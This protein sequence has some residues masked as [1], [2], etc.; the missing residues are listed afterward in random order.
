MTSGR[1]GA[2]EIRPG[3]GFETAAI[4]LE[5]SWGRLP[6]NDSSVPDAF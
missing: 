4:L 1:Q 3:A 5:N 6:Q 2:P